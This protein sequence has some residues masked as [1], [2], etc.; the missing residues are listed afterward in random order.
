MTLILGAKPCIKAK[1]CSFVSYKLKILTR[2]EVIAVPKQ[3]WQFAMPELSKHGIPH[4]DLHL[5]EIVKSRTQSNNS[6]FEEAY[7]KPKFGP[8]LQEAYEKCREICTDYAKTFYLGTLLM[9]E[10]RQKA[11]W[12]IY[13]KSFLTRFSHGKD[14]VEGMRMDTRK[15]R[16]QIYQEPYLYCYHV[17]GTVGLMSA[18]VMGIPPGASLSTQDI[19]SAALSLD[20]GNQLTNILRDVEEERNQRKRFDDDYDNLTKRAYV[21][22]TKKLMVL[23][24]AYT[25]S[26]WVPTLALVCTLR[27]GALPVG[28]FTLKIDGLY[29][30]IRRNIGVV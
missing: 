20:I 30:R 4:N 21:G 22:T 23:P 9:A 2:A 28:K 3:A 25:R 11:I 10:K 27:K 14:M 7:R 29:E 24:L 12:A 15:S 19:Y 8:F 6:V 16:Y 5:G 1:D 13:V 18:P 26:L 17:A